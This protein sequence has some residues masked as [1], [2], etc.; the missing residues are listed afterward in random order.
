M[1][2]LT[3]G[4]CL[5]PSRKAPRDP[6]VCGTVAARFP[7]SKGCPV[8]GFDLS[9]GP[10]SA[11]D[12]GQVRLSWLPPQAGTWYTGG[13]ARWN[14][15]AVEECSTSL[16]LHITAQSSH[17][18]VRHPNHARSTP[19][20]APSFRRGPST[21]ANTASLVA[22]S[23]EETGSSA[24]RISGFRAI[25]RAIATRCRWPPDNSAG[26]LSDNLEPSWT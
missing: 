4:S 11:P 13:P 12:P 9:A 17:A 15:S 26:S 8:T 18:R 25:A 21:G 22:G 5:K 7:L 3:T 14:R 2:R 24:I 10:E 23:N 6:P 16:P 20:Y 19:T 1:R